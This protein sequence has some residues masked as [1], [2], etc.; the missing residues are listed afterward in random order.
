M[1]AAA[2]VL[3][4][5]P[6]HP[7]KWRR[8]PRWMM[9]GN[10]KRRELAATLKYALNRQAIVN[11]RTAAQNSD[12]GSLRI[13]RER[14]FALYPPETFQET[15]ALV[16]WANDRVRELNPETL[17]TRKAQLKQGF[18]DMKTLK[19]DSLH[20][21]FALRPDVLAAI[22]KYLGVVPILADVDVWYSTHSGSKEYAN[23]Q[24]WHC[25]TIDTQQIKIFLY[26]T[27]V[28]ADSGPLV[29]MDASASQ[30]LRDEL[31][32]V[33]SGERMRVS[34]TEANAVVTAGDQHPITGPSG[35][36]AFVDSSRCFHYGSR[37]QQDAPPRILTVFQ[38]FTPAAFVFPVDYRKISPLKHLA[39]PDLLPIQRMALGAE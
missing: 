1:N 37:V 30:K 34:D 6:L 36:W 2:P 20:M 33:Y 15:T 7:K 25:D 27:P 31:H 3:A 19:L 28:E 21:Q 38:Y 4:P 32:Y 26:S 39:T 24:L 5:R 13:P 29:V 10:D 17:Q 8:F 22:S 12:A 11:R 14:G 23:S 9:S 18:L 35:T 16:Q